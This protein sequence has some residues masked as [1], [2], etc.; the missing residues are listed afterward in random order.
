MVVAAGVAVLALK[1]GATVPQ[2]LLL[3]GLFNAVVAVYIYTLVPEFLLRFVDWML[4][5]S[6]FRLKTRGAQHFPEE[7]PALLVCNHQSLADAMVI[8]AACRRPIRFVMSQ[9]IFN[10]PVLSFV[11]SSMKAIPI[12]GAKE[13]PEVLDRAYDEIARALADGQLVCIFPEGQLT[14]TEVSVFRS[15]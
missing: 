11:F 6:I 12:A 2:L 14:R 15:E 7:G 10:I 3:T 1:L 9:A 5:H 4:I 8:A 13:A